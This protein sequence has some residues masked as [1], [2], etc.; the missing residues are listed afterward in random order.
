[1][2]G[3]K[4][5]D[6]CQNLY[7]NCNKASYDEIKDYLGSLH[8]FN[9]A[10]DLKFCKQNNAMEIVKA[11]SKS[12]RRVMLKALK[13]AILN[14]GIFNYRDMYA[15]SEKL[16]Q[17]S[18][19]IKDTLQNRFPII[20]VD[21][22]Q[23]T[24][25]FQDELINSIFLCDSVRIQRFGDPDQAIYDSMGNEEPNETFNSNPEL[26]TLAN[27]HRF[28]EDI[29]QKVSK[30]SLNQVGKIQA[31]DDP[32]PTLDHTI[33]IYD[34]NTRPQVL[35]AFANLVLESDP[36][37][38]WT[39]VKAVGAVGQNENHTSHLQAYW[40]GYDRKKR[41]VS[42]KPGKLIDA[43][44]RDWTGGRDAHSEAQYKLIVQTIIDLLRIGNVQDDRANP[45]RYFS[46][47]SLKSWLIGNGKIQEFRQLIS[48]WIC[49][50]PQAHADWQNQIKR[51]RAILGL[52]DNDEVN[53]F[54]SYSN[55]APDPVLEANTI[56]N[57]FEAENGRTIEVATIHS[58][59]GETHDATLALETKFRTFDIHQML[60]H[61][62][63][64]DTSQITKATRMK[65]AR[66]LY[67]AFSRPRHL[68][69]FAVHG[70][71]ISD[72]QLKALVALGWSIQ[73][74]GPT[75]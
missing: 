60:D 32:D 6:I 65:F 39:S 15:F 34:D 5:K 61:I 71:H 57:Q 26:E 58:V 52:P 27:S 4:I 49:S 31:R 41:F 30:L 53:A 63:G 56:S 38:S 14:R 20:F 35:R 66:Q 21:E 64:I 46:Q 28:S 29:A 3:H 7:R 33:F 45:N 18:D 40:D 73:R 24:Q 44:N 43:V 25:K 19:A 62:A 36:E 67:V 47:N 22:M 69:C 72:E 13:E 55:E 74:L 51:L 70:D 8:Y 59:K 10:G 37:D 68:L 75:N 17:N 42:P 50:R 2:D 16:V 23:D 48:E 1:V 11:D 9:A 12:D 54:L